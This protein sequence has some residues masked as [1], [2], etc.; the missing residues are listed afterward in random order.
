MEE[1]EHRPSLSSFLREF[2]DILSRSSETL[3]AK[4]KLHA[5][6]LTKKTP[7]RKHDNYHSFFKEFSDIL[8]MSAATLQNKCLEKISKMSVPLKGST[9]PSPKRNL[10]FPQDAAQVA[11]ASFEICAEKVSSKLSV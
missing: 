1:Q 4:T 5:E 7:R 8:E 9:R 11:A 2:N 6:K 3:I 10:E